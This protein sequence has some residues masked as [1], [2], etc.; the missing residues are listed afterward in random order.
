MPTRTTTARLARGP[1]PERVLL[2]LGLS[3]ANPDVKAAASIR[4]R[5]SSSGLEGGPHAV[6]Q[7]R[8]GAYLAANPD[9]AAGGVDPLRHFLQNG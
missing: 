1:R 7:L 3:S 9:V 8:S 4:C 5:I 6:D 2:D